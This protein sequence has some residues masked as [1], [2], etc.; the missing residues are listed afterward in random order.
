MLFKKLADNDLEFLP[1][2]TNFILVKT[3]NGRK[4]FQK[5]LKLGVVVRPMDVYGLPEFIRVTI[6]KKE[7]NTKFIS[8]LLKTLGRKGK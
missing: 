6:G 3:G 7:Q 8:A 4:V 1:T 2:E 5:M